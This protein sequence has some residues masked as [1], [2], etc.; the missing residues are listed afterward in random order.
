[1][2]SCDNPPCVNPAHLKCG[3][4]GDNSRD[5]SA[6]KR[7]A[8]RKGSKNPSVK[9]TDEQALAIR[10]DSRSVR[11]IMAAFGIGESQVRRIRSGESWLHL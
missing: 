8:D 6:K 9:L 7:D 4:A 10:D 1:M 11:D 5:R 3:T 2:H